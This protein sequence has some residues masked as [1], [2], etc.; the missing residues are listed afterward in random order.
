MFSASDSGNDPLPTRTVKIAWRRIPRS[1]PPK[2]AADERVCDYREVY[3][4][5]DA[6][7]VK[8]QASRC[9]QCG[10]PLCM[11]GCPLRNRIP[12]WLALA[13]EGRFLEAAS[14]SQATSNIPEI[15]SRICPQERL[16]EGSCVL[17]GHAKPIA[18]GAIE[19]FIN[20]YAFANGGISAACAP[21]NGLRVAVVGSGPAGLA[22]ADQLVRAG[23]AVTVFEALDQPGGLLRY[24]IP[25]FKLEK[26]IVDRRIDVL[27]RRGVEFR[28]GIRVG[29]DI[30]LADLRAEYDAVF[31]GGGAQKPKPVGI[32]GDGLA[33]IH[34]ALPFLI[35]KNVRN[36]AVHKSIEV[37]GRRVAVLG[38]GDTA[39]DCLR[40]ALRSGARE[41]VCIYRRDLANMPGSRKEYLNATEEGARFEFLTNPVEIIGDDCGG[42]AGVRCIRMELGPPAADGRCTP[43]PIPGSEFTIA[44]D[45]IIVAYGFDPEPLPSC[46]DDSIAVNRWGGIVVDDNR[47]TSL[48]G[49]FAGGDASRGPS[50]VSESA[51][52]GREA[53]AAIDRYLRMYCETSQRRKYL[54]TA[55]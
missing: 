53:A 9:I 35:Q 27:R 47:M 32:P 45:V 39:M 28:C 42:V 49:V 12:E 18:I 51:R 38:G 2:R 54:P 31:W 6:A 41:A 15:C 14:V 37:A 43:R 8:R 4:L 13:A 50:L 36:S 46:G 16:C 23:Y 10:E 34:E 55:T 26:A 21:A 25:S 40:T 48:P 7:E 22:C 52:D 30:R 20:E 19:Q 17:N 3:G 5:L 29:R 24:G 1:Y 44:A 33:D 11:E